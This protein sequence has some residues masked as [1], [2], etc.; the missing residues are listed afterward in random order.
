MMVVKE[1]KMFSNDTDSVIHYS[2]EEAKELV[3]DI[4]GFNEEDSLDRECIEQ[5]GWH[6]IPKDSIV[7]LLM[8][9][10]D[11]DYPDGGLIKKTVEEWCNELGVCYFG[12]TEY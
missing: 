2:L 7:P 5:L 9:K 6:E 11:E 4:Y 1:L 8:E 10:G 3:Y 12:G